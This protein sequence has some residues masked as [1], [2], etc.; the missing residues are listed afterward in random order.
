MKKFTK[1]IN[2]SLECWNGIIFPQ[3]P[4]ESDGACPYYM[5]CDIC[6]N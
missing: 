5:L 6:D 4:A 2:Q 3:L 1:K